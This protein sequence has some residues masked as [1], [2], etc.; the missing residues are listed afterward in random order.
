MTDHDVIAAFAD[1]ERVDT[2]R[3]KAAL[4]SADGRDY[5]ADI[6]ALRE[7]TDGRAVAA[8]DRAT[9][10][11]PRPAFRWAA[12]AAG[13]LVAAASGY[14]VGTSRTTTPPAQEIKQQTASPPAPTIV[15]PLKP[16]AKWTDRTPGGGS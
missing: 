14:A 1:G 13:V 15:I 11:R 16:G 7:I 10:A 6:L 9:A 2:E 8:A 5:L 4:A 12:I 3:L